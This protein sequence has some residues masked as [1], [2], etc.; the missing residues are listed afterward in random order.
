M[1]REKRMKSEAF[2]LL[3]LIWIVTAVLGIR[4]SATT[5]DE[6][7]QISEDS[8][9]TLKTGRF[10]Y[11]FEYNSSTPVSAK[12]EPNS[13]EY[14]LRKINK[15]Y[16]SKIDLSIDF[17]SHSF[18][19]SD[20]DLRDISKLLEE[21]GLP[22]KH[23]YISDTGAL[24]VRGDIELTFTPGSVWGGKGF[25]FLD[26]EEGYN[27]YNMLWSGV[28]PSWIFSLDSDNNATFTVAESD[29]GDLLRVEF[30][31]G[32][33]EGRRIKIEC[34]SSLGYRYRRIERYYQNRLAFEKVAS[35][36]RMIDGVPYPFVQSQ[37]VF[38][39]GGDVIIEEKNTMKSVELNVELSGADFQVFVPAGAKFQSVLGKK[40]SYGHIK[41][42]R[43]IGIEEA[44][45]LA[46]SPAK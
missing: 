27:T 33:Q 13:I 40:G 31:Y 19:I 26:K 36:Y 21:N 18:I 3:T 6:L 23:R 20:I 25:L 7:R 14:K 16:L 12:I 35:D 32:K 30:S 22:E 42:D 1:L 8:R 37:R 46:D 4:A 2:R 11:I 38:N 41:Q 10:V 24:I 15:H 28:I 9:N 29:E 43:H 5:M 44:L 39:E 34:D 45:E 17:K